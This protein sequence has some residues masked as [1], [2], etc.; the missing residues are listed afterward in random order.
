LGLAFLGILTNDSPQVPPG[1]DGVQRVAVFFPLAYMIGGPV[2]FVERK[3]LR[4]L[5]MPVEMAMKLSATAH[6]STSSTDS[7]HLPASLKD[8]QA[9]DQSQTKN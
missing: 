1:P 7:T 5:D 9:A 4:E 6:L 2:A 8:R 3:Y